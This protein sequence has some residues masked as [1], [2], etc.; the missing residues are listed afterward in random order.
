MSICDFLEFNTVYGKLTE[1][2][3]IKFK[4]LKPN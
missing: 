3:Q 1:K 2:D 4:K